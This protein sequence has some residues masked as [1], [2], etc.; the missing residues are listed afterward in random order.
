MK[1]QGRASFKI[2]SS[3]FESSRLIGI[4]PGGTD[5]DQV[6][7]KGAFQGPALEPAE[8]L[9]P[10]DLQG[11]KIPVPCKILVEAS[12]TKAVDAPIHLV[13]DKGPQ[14]LIKVGP[15][16]P[17]VPAHT[18]TP[19]DRFILEKTVA[20][21]VAHRT[22]KRM[23]QHEPL[24]HVFSELHCLFICGGDDH[25]VPGFHHAAHIDPFVW[26]FHELHRTHPAGAHGA[27]GRMVAEA[28]Y[29]DAEAFRGFD[30]LR[31]LGHCYFLSVNDQFRH[32]RLLTIHGSRFWAL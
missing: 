26:A 28:G 18:M 21:L 11:A 10:P 15:L 24:D 6:S 16:L 3:A 12:A 5:I 23:V 8:V 31:P 2:P 7:G 32:S 30:H 27:Q 1:A 19:R 20:A 29:H 13:P 4:N 17:R 14:V 22:V 25:A 9:A